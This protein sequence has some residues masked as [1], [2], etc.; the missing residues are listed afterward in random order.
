MCKCDKTKNGGEGY[1]KIKMPGAG[2]F[3]SFAFDL[4][5]EAEPNAIELEIS[6][7]SSEKK[8]ERERLGDSQATKP[9]PV[10][11][12]G[13]FFDSGGPPWQAEY[14]PSVGSSAN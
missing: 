10:H 14:Q 13:L 5:M 4:T 12:Q 6:T 3:D 11:R 2:Q 9:S 1:K 7:Q 8:G